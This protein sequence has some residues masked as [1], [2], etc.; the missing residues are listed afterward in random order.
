LT[1]DPS[2]EPLGHRITASPITVMDRER[3]EGAPSL[4][5]CSGH[6]RHRSAGALDRFLNVAAPTLTRRS[7]LFLSETTVKT[8][9]PRATLGRPHRAS[10]GPGTT[11]EDHGRIREGARS[12][13]PSVR[14]RLRIV[15]TRL[16]TI[17]AMLKM[18]PAIRNRPVA[19]ALCGSA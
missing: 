2:L 18:P 9:P 17:T 19:V 12:E 6:A 5:L 10:H 15:A 4:G 14:V 11:R 16:G 13:A 8:I 3:R 1:G 7:Q